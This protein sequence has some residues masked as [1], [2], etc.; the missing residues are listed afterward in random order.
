[1]EVEY[2]A[3]GTTIGIATELVG[4]PRPAASTPWLAFPGSYSARCSSDGG[5]N[6]LQISPRYAAPALSPTPDATWGLHLVDANIALANLT[7]LVR[8]QAAA[9][10]RRR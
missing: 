2:F 3:A 10:A 5:G 9:Y 6:V 8:R 7:R 4:F 1:M